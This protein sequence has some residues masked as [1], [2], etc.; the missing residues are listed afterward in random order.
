MR[1]VHGWRRALRWALGIFGGLIG[2]VALVII[3]A[4]L[5]FSTGWGRGVMRSQ[6]ESKMNAV[7]VG[8]AKVGGVEGNPFKDLVLTN[9]VINGPD[10]QPAIKVAR[11]TVKLPLLPLISHQLRVDK[12]IADDLDVQLKRD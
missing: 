9:V 10:H 8:G 11:L 5:M 12:I 4:Y 6:I 3:A 2:L 7:F 1:T